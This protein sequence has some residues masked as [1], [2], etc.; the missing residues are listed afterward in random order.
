MWRLFYARSLHYQA[1]KTDAA[2]EG[3]GT[4]LNSRAYLFALAVMPKILARPHSAA[5]V[6][7]LTAT[8]YSS[9]LARIFAAR[10]ITESS[11]LEHSLAK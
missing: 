9:A 2:H 1:V 8:G 6:E 4:L 7:H 11:Q 5:A 3:G 10:G